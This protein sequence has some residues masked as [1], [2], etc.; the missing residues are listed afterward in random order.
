[1]DKIYLKDFKNWCPLKEKIEKKE[2]RPIYHER[3]IWW[4]NLGTNVGFEQDGKGKTFSRPILVYK[5]FSSKIFFGFPLSSK[6]KSENPFYRKITFLGREQSAILN[7]L[8]TI[9]SKRLINRMGRLP[10]DEF[11]SLSKEFL[12]IIST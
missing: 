9:D 6:V 5:K 1:M 8:R 10:E 11:I 7:Q 4:C 3:E 2:K 12:E